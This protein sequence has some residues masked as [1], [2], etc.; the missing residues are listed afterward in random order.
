MLRKEPVAQETVRLDELVSG[1]LPL[2]RNDALGANVSI[3]VKSAP[4]LPPIQV[5]PVQVQQVVMNL[6]L[7][8]IDAIQRLGPA[9]GEI[10]VEISHGGEDGVLVTVADNGPGIRAEDLDE[11][12]K[13]FMTTKSGGMGMGLAICKSILEA[14]GGTISVESGVSG[15]CCFSFVLPLKQRAAS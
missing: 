2:I 9:G 10:E 7:N 4:N 15:G 1:V 5:D 6:L 3:N 13:P 11:V 14:H 8:S 12:F